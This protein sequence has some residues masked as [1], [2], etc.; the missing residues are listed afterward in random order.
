MKSKNEWLP[1]K[2]FRMSIS[3]KNLLLVINVGNYIFCL[4]I[5]GNSINKTWENFLR[6]NY[7]FQITR[8]SV[9]IDALKYMLCLL[10][11]MH[12]S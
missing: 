3:G 11:K 2:L 9:L 12:S 7:I 10:Y 8:S 6:N 4:S 1:K 5:I